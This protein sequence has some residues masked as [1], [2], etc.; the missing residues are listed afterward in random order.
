[1]VFFNHLSQV[2]SEGF[3]ILPGVYSKKEVSSMTELIESKELNSTSVLKSKQLFAIRQLLLE[4]PEL[5]PLIFN[6]VLKSLLRNYENGKP[7]FLTKAIYFNKPKSSNWFVGYHQDLTISVSQK[8]DCSG[9]INWTSKRGQ[10]GV[11]PPLE[12]LENTLT[13]R[14]HLDE[15]NESNG[16][17]W[18]IPQSHLHGIIRV[19]EQSDKT[20]EICCNVS[21]GGIMLMKPLTLHA[22][23]KSNGLVNRRVIHLEFCAMPLPEN[24]AWK[25]FQSF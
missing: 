9:F 11:Q 14:I 16:A 15:T 17:L 21:S 4:I 6:D 13:V 18:V 2:D 24:L 19:S 22:S 7:Y 20:A 25:E 10:L 12:F 8:K 1:M 5:K 23:K 3:S